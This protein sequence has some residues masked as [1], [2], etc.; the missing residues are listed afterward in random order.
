MKAQPEFLLRTY[1]KTF[2]LH[3]EDDKWHIFLKKKLEV[4]NVEG[5]EPILHPPPSPTP[6]DIDWS[7]VIQ[8]PVFQI[9]YPLLIHYKLYLFHSLID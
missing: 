2:F 6:L 7:T 3:S 1:F 9:Y 8:T 4:S 5:M